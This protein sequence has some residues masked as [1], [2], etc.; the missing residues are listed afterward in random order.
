[1]PRLFPVVLL[2]SGLAF[3]TGCANQPGTPGTQAKKAAKAKAGRAG[4]PDVIKLGRPNDF[5][6]VYLAT[7]SIQ[8][9]GDKVQAWQ[10]AVHDYPVPLGNVGTALSSEALVSFDCAQKKQA[11]LQSRT[12]SDASGKKQ[13]GEPVRFP[14]KPESYNPIKP[15][16][17]AAKAL[18]IV[19]VTGPNPGSRTR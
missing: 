10:F 7:R 1:M 2:V 11:L 12:F 14:D 4:L 17:V 19:C 9:Q 5:T 13:I 8:K 3:V 18:S 16:S 15:K 6:T